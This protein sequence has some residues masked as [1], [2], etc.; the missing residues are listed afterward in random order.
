[1][2]STN[3]RRLE[4]EHVRQVYDDIA[5]HFS[6]TRYKAWPI[7]ESFIQNLAAFSLGLDVGCGNGKNMIIRQHDLLCTGFDL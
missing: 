3:Q 1:M 5:H 2:E 6:N 7:V 4:E